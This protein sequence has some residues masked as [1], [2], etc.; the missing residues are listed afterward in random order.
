MPEIIKTLVN[1]AKEGDVQAARVLLDRSVPALKATDTPVN[2][3][4]RGSLKEAGEAILEAVGNGD[5][6]PDQSAKMFQGLGAQV[7]VED[8]SELKARLEALERVLQAQEQ[9]K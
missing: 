2:L 3:M 9:Q 7:R 1:A 5:I 4:L 8:T 6:T